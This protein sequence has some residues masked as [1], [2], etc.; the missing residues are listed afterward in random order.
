MGY[1]YGSGILSWFTRRLLT[2]GDYDSARLKTDN[3]RTGF[4]EGRQFRTFHEYNIASGTSQW[5]RATVTD[6]IILL[7]TSVSLDISRLRLTLWVGGTPQGTWDTPVPTI[8]KNTMARA[9][10]HTSF[11]SLDAGGSLVLTGDETTNPAGAIQLDIARLISE[12]QGN[13][14]NTVGGQIADERGVG[15]NVYYY[16]LQNIDGATAEGVF[17][18]DWENQLPV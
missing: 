6:D 18:A 7:N 13:N 10:V 5:I 12:S 14:A 2:S 1:S 17:S 15:A 11:V 3:T 8:P 16:R 9:P 4:D